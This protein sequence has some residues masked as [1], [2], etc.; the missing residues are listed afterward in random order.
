[1][2]NSICQNCRADFNVTAEDL[3]FYEKM[4]VPAPLTCPACRFQRRMMFRNERT[5][6]KRTC[7]RCE[8]SMVSIFAPEAKQPVYCPAC[9]WSDDWDARDYGMAYDPS[10]P[11]FEQLKELQG[12]VPSA[13]LIIGY[14]SLVRSDYVNH[15]GGSKDCYFI[16]NADFCENVLYSSTVVHV[17]DSMDISLSTNSEL[18]YETVNASGTRVFFSQNCTSCIDTYF[19]KD[20]TGCLN[21]IG[22]VGLHNKSYHIFN[23][24]VSKEVYEQFL[25]EARLDTREGI[26]SMREKAEA[27]SVTFPRRAYRG[28][29]NVSSTG[30]YIY[31]CKNAKDCYQTIGLEDGAYCQF[32]T[33]KPTKDAYD[34]SE[35]GMNS[36][37][38]VDAITVGENCANIK[39]CAG[40]WLN[41]SNIEYCMYTVSSQNCFG[42]VNLKKG[43]YCILNKQYSKEEYERIKAQIMLEMTERTYTDSKGRIFPYGEFLPYDL[44]YFA[45]NESQADQ[46][47]PMK[48]EEIQER[49]FSYREKEG[50]SHTPTISWENVPESIHDVSDDIT[51]EILECTTCSTP[52]RIVAP[53]LKLLRRFNFPI[54]PSCSNCRHL[55]RL[56]QLNPPELYDRN[57]GKC[58]KDIR[59][60]FSPERPDIVYC[61]SCYQQAIM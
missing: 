8:K 45:Y 19:S 50:T 2:K 60:S 21:V 55:Y 58:G 41:C 46:Y 35:W 11:F 28:T 26:R 57:C 7:S 5:L 42:C 12:R 3:S 10:R 51:K 4:Q 27:F 38:V 30:E 49:G 37:R 20:C 25:R 54:P 22:C 40:A 43:S 1:M 34:L 17:K 33:L 31:Q 47:F 36:E 56:A 53:E 16:F 18:M 52:Y 59:T 15:A 24:P 23:E 61:E 6:Y 44:S 39:Y 13:A 32:L 14:S 29:H 48:K 9:W